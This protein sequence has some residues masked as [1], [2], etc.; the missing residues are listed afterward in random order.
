MEL[1]IVEI[2]HAYVGF[3]TSDVKEVVRAARLSPALNANANMKGMLNLRGTVVP[4]VSLRTLLGL[5]E[6]NIVSTDHF[7]L[8]LT[9]ST[10]FAVHVDRAIDI[11]DVL[12]S[13]SIGI[14][15]DLAASVPHADFGVVHIHRASSLWTQVGLSSSSGPLGRDQP[16]GTASP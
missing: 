16:V 3:P 10:T 9:Q 14:D 4:V 6:R 11:L 5:A 1:L 7:I 2:D 13:P 12:D 8:L 15:R